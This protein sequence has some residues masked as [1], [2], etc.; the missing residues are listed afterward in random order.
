MPPSDDER[1]RERAQQTSGDNTVPGREPVAVPSSAHAPAGGPG[2][3][4]TITEAAARMAV[5]LARFEAF[6]EALAILS[7]AD[8]VNDAIARVGELRSVAKPPACGVTG[9]LVAGDVVTVAGRDRV[10]THVSTRPSKASPDLSAILAYVRSYEA[11]REDG[12]TIYG[13]YQDAAD[14]IADGIEERFK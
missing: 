4:G 12:T 13:P 3:A 2:E 8:C 1:R 14:M 7:N 9:R 11:V 10:L 6:G 5:R